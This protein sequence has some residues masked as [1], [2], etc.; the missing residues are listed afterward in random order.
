MISY[1]DYARHTGS[2]VCCFWAN[3]ENYFTPEVSLAVKRVRGQGK[4]LFHWRK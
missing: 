1:K 3:I 2:S 4:L